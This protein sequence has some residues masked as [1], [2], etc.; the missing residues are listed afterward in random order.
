MQTL[1]LQAVQGLYTNGGSS[2]RQTGGYY[3]G[4]RMSAGSG[5]GRVTSSWGQ[6]ASSRGY[7]Y[8]GGSYR[9]TP[10]LAANRRAK[11]KRASASRRRRRTRYKRWGR[12]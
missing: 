7:G 10:N 11:A 5:G 4:R 9:A 1:I 3:A 8:P 12:K 2:S 6:S